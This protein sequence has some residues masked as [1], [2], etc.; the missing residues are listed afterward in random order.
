ME[1]GFI[2][3]VFNPPSFFLSA[4]NH[5]SRR[6]MAFLAVA[7]LFSLSSCAPALQ[8][9]VNS[10]VVAHNLEGASV[11]LG[12]KPSV[13][14]RN[15]EL[16]YWLDR[17][18]VEQ[19]SGR[20]A[21]S[22]QSFANAQR[23][24]DELYTKSLT[25]MAGTWLLNDYAAPYRG[26]DYEYILVNI[27]QA[28]NY[29]MI[30]E[31]NEALVEAR[32]MDSKLNL[33]NSLHEGKNIYTEDA[34]GR[35]FMGILY[36]VNGTSSDL[37]D[38][39]ISYARAYEDYAKT[40]GENFGVEAPG[41]LKENLLTLAHFMGGDAFRRYRDEFSDVKLITLDEKNKKA[42]V[43]LVQYTGF[44]PVKVATVVPI[45]LDPRHITQMEFPEFVARHSEITGSELAAAQSEQLSYV[46]PS[47]VGQDIVVVAQKVLEGRKAQVIAKAVARPVAKYAAERVI[48]DKIHDKWGDLA[49]IGFDLLSSIYNLTTERA[50]LR[51][52]QTL[53][54]QIRVARLLLE[55]GEYE[56][57]VQ[58]YG[59]SSRLL[60]KESLGRSTVEAGEKK[61][62]VFRNY[63]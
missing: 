37:N 25:K 24:Y 41:L 33:I 18:M 56:F 40:G 48:E 46:Q 58:T 8:T 16:L 60:G 31:Y 43:Y 20:Y 14:G 51:S 50:D 62:F 22:I 6:A 2:E 23:K 11:A 3:P 5:G 9:R 26:D 32:D 29:V 28:I 44:S 21:E 13:Y 15:N 19:C 55:P 45:P 38:A 12:E 4:M 7:L 63:R 17:G 1:D 39:F 59:A 27:F 61:F 36:E 53:P 34:F 10:L 47:F 57:F 35:F 42:E 30:G 54:A 52:W 49:A